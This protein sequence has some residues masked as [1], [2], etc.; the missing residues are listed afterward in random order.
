MTDE[1]RPE[2]LAVR[3]GAVVIGLTGTA[4]LIYVAAYAQSWA[5]LTFFHA[6]RLVYLVSAAEMFTSVVGYIPALLFLL[7]AL[8]THP[9][10]RFLREDLPI[11]IALAAT[12]GAVITV[13]GETAFGSLL[14]L[15]TRAVLLLLAVIFGVTAAAGM[16]MEAAR[17]VLH[18]GERS[19]VEAITSTIACLGILIVLVPTCIG[20]ARARYV[21]ADI[22]RRMT[23][24]VI[25][26]DLR[27]SENPTLILG[28]DRVFILIGTKES[29]YAVKPVPWSDVER[30]RG[31]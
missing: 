2:T 9:M 31:H 28:N 27:Q 24:V 14:S 1:N 5:F 25:R 13:L 4:S 17:E 18:G 12:A 20:R 10:Q 15:T 19:V 6:G 30:L 16:G 26:G 21:A 23:S 11:N 22:R 7:G 3:V 8:A 29:D